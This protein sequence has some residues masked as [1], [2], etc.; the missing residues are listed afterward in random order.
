MLKSTMLTLS[1]L[2]ASP[3][4]IVPISGLDVPPDTE[5]VPA[6]AR[7]ITPLSLQLYEPFGN[8]VVAVKKPLAS[9]TT[10]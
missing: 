10:L 5:R 7:L 8:P 9:V 2:L 4:L 3:A 1:E 6:F